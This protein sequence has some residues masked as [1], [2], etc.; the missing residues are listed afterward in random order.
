MKLFYLIFIFALVNVYSLSAQS[1]KK[2]STKS[3]LISDSSKIITAK[4][5]TAVKKKHI[6][7]IA[8]RRS[9]LIPGWGQAYNREYWKIPIIYGALAIPAYTFV[10]NNNY[11]KMCKFAYDAVYAA[12][13]GNGNG[14]LDSSQLKFIDPRVR[15]T[16]GTLLGLSDYQNYR[17]VFRKSRDYSIFWF[18]ILWGI[19]VADATVFAHLKDFDVTDDLTMHIQPNINPVTKTP[20][21]GFVFNLK[22][23]PKQPKNIA[24]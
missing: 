1:E 24:R 10:D 7:R 16:D 12:T 17:N 19:N 3:F 18:I 6:P 11:Y 5:D 8:T 20:E 4:K 22:N 2:D 23:A 14:V 13:I 9:A 21:I 15:R